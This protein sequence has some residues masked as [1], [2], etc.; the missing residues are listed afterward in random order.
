MDLKLVPWYWQYVVS[1]TILLAV[2]MFDQ[3]KS[4]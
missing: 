4:K 1:G 2:V 3:L